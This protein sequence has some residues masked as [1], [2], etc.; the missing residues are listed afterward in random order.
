MQPY[1]VD[2]ENTQ[3]IQD[4]AINLFN[5]YQAFPI[6]YALRDGCPVFFPL[7]GC[8]AH[9]HAE[10]AES[11]CIEPVELDAE[12]AFYLCLHF[13]QK[14]KQQ[15]PTALGV[16]IFTLLERMFDFLLAMRADGTRLLEFSINI[17]GR[18]ITLYAGDN[19]QYFSLCARIL[20]E[21]CRTATKLQPHRP[22]CVWQINCTENIA[23]CALKIA[24]VLWNMIQVPA[25]PAAVFLQRLKFL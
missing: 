6:A 2:V 22:E 14:T 24:P 18:T 1:F 21:D 3:Q 17:S 20:M 13:A 5:K 25:L 10:Q 23:A 7:V 19:G 16:Y 15:P 11:V 4:F 12:T 9:E 8:D